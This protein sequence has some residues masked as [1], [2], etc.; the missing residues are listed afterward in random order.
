[1]ASARYTIRDNKELLE[2]IRIKE[3]VEGRRLV[4]VFHYLNNYSQHMYIFCPVVP[5]SNSQH[6]DSLLSIQPL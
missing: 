6:Q 4:D 1:M 5:T 2:E 3:P